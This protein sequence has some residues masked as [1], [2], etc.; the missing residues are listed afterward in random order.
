M[1]LAKSV[2]GHAANLP[3]LVHSV[4]VVEVPG[5]DKESLTGTWKAW[6]SEAGK[7]RG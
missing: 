3:D 5:G 4:R 7:G 1:Q 2:E 6:V